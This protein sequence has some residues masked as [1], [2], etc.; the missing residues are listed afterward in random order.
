MA[1]INEFD[2]AVAG[3]RLDY[4]LDVLDV[5]PGATYG[6]AEFAAD[7]ALQGQ[8]MTIGQVERLRSTGHG[9]DNS[10]VLA[11]IEAAVHVEPAYFSAAAP[12]VGLVEDL[13]L[14]LA[15]AQFRGAYRRAGAVGLSICGREVAGDDRA[16]LLAR[17]RAITNLLERV[18]GLVEEDDGLDRLEDVDTADHVSSAQVTAG[19]PPRQRRGWF[20]RH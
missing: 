4:L 16:G 11:A 15:M 13:E 7:L 17:Y 8:L 6:N 20:R 3:R 19:R 18:E 1:E 9:L 5:R 2:A 12:T 14:L 10:V